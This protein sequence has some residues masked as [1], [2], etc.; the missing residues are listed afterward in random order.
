MTDKIVNDSGLDILFRTARTF[1]AWQNK[2]VSDVLIR[3]V[4]DLLKQAPTAANSSPAR[5]VFVKSPEAKQK[6]KPHLDP[7][8]VDKTMNAPLTVIIAH[9]MKFYDQLPKL[10]P[11]ADARSWYAGNDAAIADNAFRNGS[12]QGAYLIMAARALGLDCGPM[13]GFNKAG[14]K[15][16][17]LSG[18]DYEPNFLCNIGY[19]D[20]AKLH[21]RLPRLSF[22]DACKIV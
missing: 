21:P 2:D 12:L 18:T 7:G 20:T 17:F 16:A 8:N 14:I 10:F 6:L 11:H 15:D 22:D 4:Y 9:D 13:S 5:F 19:G 3:S 1:G